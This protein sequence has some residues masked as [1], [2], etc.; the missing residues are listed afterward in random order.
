MIKNY[1]FFIYF[2]LNNFVLNKI[3]MSSY[4]ITKIIFF[5]NIKINNFNYKLIYFNL[6]FIDLFGERKLK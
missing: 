1:N 5:I 3:N 2:L 6:I 4:N